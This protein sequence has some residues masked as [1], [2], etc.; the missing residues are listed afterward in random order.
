MQ[1]PLP[2]KDIH[3]P[4][5]IG[6]WPPALGWWL[7]LLVLALLASLSWWIYKRITRNT[8]LKQAKIMLDKIKHEHA[9]DNLKTLQ[10]LSSWLRRVTITLSPRQESAGLTGVTWLHYLDKSVEGAPFSEGV[11]Q[12]LAD[13]HFRQSAPNDLDITALLAL[14]E[15]WLAEQSQ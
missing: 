10:Q 4:T 6:N 8:P 15:T 11:G 14:C 1:D 2:L 12:Y 3:L 5:A 9:D 13:A 7:L